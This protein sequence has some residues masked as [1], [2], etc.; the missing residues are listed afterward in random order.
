MTP[1]PMF[2]LLLFSLNNTEILRLFAKKLLWFF[3][4]F[5]YKNSNNLKENEMKISNLSNENRTWNIVYDYFK[6]IMTSD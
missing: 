4:E 5:V 6:E 1:I 2:T 3:D